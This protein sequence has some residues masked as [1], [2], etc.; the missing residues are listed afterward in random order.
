VSYILEALRKSEQQRQRGMAPRLLAAQPTY[1]EDTQPAF[2]LHGLIAAALIGGG[3]AIGWWKPWQQARLPAAA[4]SSP[5]KPLEPALRL[6]MPASLSLPVLPEAS[7]R[8]EQEA[9]A[10]KSSVAAHPAPKPGSLKQDTLLPARAPAQTPEWPAKTAVAAPRAPAQ[11]VREKSTAP[12]PAPAPLEKA[13][14]PIQE[15]S[16][17]AAAADPAQ[18]QSVVLMAELPLAI[19]QEIPALSIPVHTYSSAPKE[20]IVGINDRLLQEGE[21]VAPGLKLE[22]IAPDSVV[23]SYKNYRFRRGLQ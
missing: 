13:S 5:A 8:S 6:A 17:E 16:A 15:K 4:E 18:V 11:P 12:A 7:S 22:E 21:Y 2:L 19:R 1:E 3:V 9:P 23:F 20:R 10:Q 14:A